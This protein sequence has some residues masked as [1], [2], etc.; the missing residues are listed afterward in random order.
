MAVVPTATTRPPRAL[1]A[2][3]AAAVTSGTWYRSA[4][5]ASPASCEL[6]PVCSV[7]G[8]TPTP[9]AMRRGDEVGGEWARGRGHLGAA[10]VDAEHGLVVGQ[11]VAAV[12]VAVGDRPP[13][14]A[15]RRREVAAHGRAPEPVADARGRGV[16]AWIGLDQ[17]Q[18]RAVE[19]DVL[20]RLG[21][22]DRSPRVGRRTQLDH[23]GAV[24]EAGRDVHH[25]RATRRADGVGLGGDGR[26]GVDHDQVAGLQLVGQVAEDAMTDVVRGPGD[27][28]PYAVAGDAA[29]LRRCRGRGLGWHREVGGRVQG[30][31]GHQATP[32]RFVAISRAR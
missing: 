28:Q 2:L 10:R 7:T 22:E 26:A 18:R 13:G 3:T 23:P 14:P 25:D 17:G 4:C 5:G 19:R 29:V 24:V 1:V 12:E 15:E 21:V 8:L 30:G 11:R 9:L 31:G 16:L 32:V 27:E 20:A 6:S